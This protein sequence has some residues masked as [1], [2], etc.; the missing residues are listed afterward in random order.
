M[1]SPTFENLASILP[2]NKGVNN[3]LREYEGAVEPS[4]G[5]FNHN[6]FVRDAKNVDI[7]KQG[8]VSRRSGYSMVTPGHTHSLW[9]APGVSFG[10]CVR[11]GQLVKFTDVDPQGVVLQEV[12]QSLP[13]SY[14]F[15]NGYVYWSNIEQNGCVRDDVCAGWGVQVGGAP[16]VASGAGGLRKGVYGV[17]TTHM[18]DHGVEGGASEPIYKQLEDMSS[19]QVYIDSVLHNKCNIYVTEADS[20]VFYLAKS[21]ESEG[22]VRIDSED[23]G[24]GRVLSTAGLKPPSPGHLLTYASG[25]VYFARGQYVMFTE[26]LRYTLYDPGVGVFMFVGNVTLLAGCETG[27]YVADSRATYFLSGTNPFDMTQRVISP[28]SAVQGSLSWADGTY[29]DTLGDVPVWWS[30]DGRLLAGLP[31]GELRDLSSD[32]VSVGEFQSGASL[33][34]RENGMIQAVSSLAQGQQDGRAVA[35]DSVVAEVRT[36][37]IVLNR[38]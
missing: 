18:C 2:A 27:I 24:V 13:I 7:T 3:L 21:V 12:H 23:I 17:A 8:S 20:E 6:D 32:R 10:L 30:S 9:S 26:P 38:G 36:N 34:R 1:A 16:T 14:V 25:R 31:G 11:D 19:L 35:A 15:V 5:G 28:T 33:V 29:F 22:V 37:K 4:D